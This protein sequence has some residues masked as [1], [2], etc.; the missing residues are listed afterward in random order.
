MCGMWELLPRRRNHFLA[1]SAAL[2]LSYSRKI[3]NEDYRPC[4]YTSMHAMRC[5]LNKNKI[6]INYQLTA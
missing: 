6:A 1:L 2:G 4:L 5:H 3:S